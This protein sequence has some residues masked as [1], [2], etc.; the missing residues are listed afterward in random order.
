MDHEHHKH[1]HIERSASEVHIKENDHKKLENLSHYQH[2]SH[3]K[4]AGHSVSDFRK[5]FI[6]CITVTLPVMLL[7]EMIRRWIGFDLEF[8]GDHYILAALSAFIFIYGGWPFLKG[9]YD[10]VRSDAIGMMTLIGV[11]VTTAWVY[12]LA[13]TFGLKGMDFYWEM[14]TLIDIMLIG[15]YYE[16]K[17]VSGASQALQLLVKMLPATAHRLVNG[18]IEDV[19]V[20]EILKDDIVVVKPGEKIPVDGV[21]INGESYLDESMLTGESK[22]VKKSRDQEVIA[23]AINGNWRSRC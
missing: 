12:S 21:V 2:A 3:D 14:A 20:N 22:P 7:S 23:G 18:N 8:S 10:E 1:S 13:V 17:S 9:M 19:P 16:M 15:H 11:A 6:I 4:H 5:R